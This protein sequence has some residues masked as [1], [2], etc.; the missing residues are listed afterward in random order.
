MT[1]DDR[2]QAAPIGVIET[3]TDGR[4]VD[5]NEAA[6]TTLETTPESLHGTDIR[7][8]FPKSAAGT[9]RATFDGDSVTARSFEE[10]YPRIDRWLSVDVHV[11]ETILVYVRDRTERRED[12]ERVER[13]ERRLERV[14]DINGLVAAVLRRV[15]DAS[16]RTAVGQTVCER[17][18][19]TDRYR[20][21]WVGER[22]FPD[23][24]LQTLAAAGDAPDLRDQIGDALEAE[25]T[26]PEQTALETGETQ[27]VAAIAEDETVPRGVR[28]AAFGNGLQSCLAVPLAYRD[29]TYGVVS[30]YSG[31]EDGFSD[32]ERAGLETLGR[33]AGFA[34]RALR[35]EDLLVADTLTEVTI[36]VGDESVPLVRAAREAGCPIALEGAVPRGDGAVVCYLDTEQGGDDTGA[37]AEGSDGMVSELEDML[38]DDEAVTDVRRIEDEGGPQLQATLVSETPVT[39]LVAWGATVTSAEYTADSGRLVAEAPP[40]GDVRRLVEAV[41]ATAAET[42]LV[43]KAETPRTSDS[44]EAFRS[45]L[46][47]RLTDRQRTVLR[48]AHLSGYFASPRGSTSEEV[49]ETL[50]IAGSTLL[51]HLR[52]AEQELVGAYFETDRESPP[53]DG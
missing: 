14:Q 27:V 39:T 48:T 24:S 2:L 20:F 31:R 53:T 41:D 7:D 44:P 4:V 42:D 8:E 19:G 28:R 1:L 40:D 10:Y 3:S 45:D 38:A 52:R 51:Y 32:G 37:T 23:D 46:D 34:I 11:G 17:L 49:A 33:V 12:A 5:A 18:G 13:L 30:V 26:L 22:D 21:A 36:D 25:G 47:E 50:D 9:L 29:T 35:Q 16:D 43:S 15:I 6:A